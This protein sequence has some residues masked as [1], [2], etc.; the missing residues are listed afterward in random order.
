MPSVLVTG[1]SRGIGRATALRLA[2][3]GWNVVAGVRRPED[4]EALSAAQPGRIATVQLDVTDEQQIA[5]LDGALPAELDAL[6]NNAGVVV[7]SPIE[8]VPLSGF[9]ASSR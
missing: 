1:A 7:G 4:G 2:A 3:R 8:A 6:V 9:D 5:T